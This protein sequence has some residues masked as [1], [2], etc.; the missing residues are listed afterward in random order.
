MRSC[1]TANASWPFCDDDDDASRGGGGA[2]R[3]SGS[4]R[5]SRRTATTTRSRTTRAARA[6]RAP[7]R[8]RARRADRRRARALRQAA[9]PDGRPA[10]PALLQRHQLRLRGAPPRQQGAARAAQRRERARLRR[11]AR[12]LARRPDVVLGSMDMGDHKVRLTTTANNTTI[13]TDNTKNMLTPL[14]SSSTT[15]SMWTW[16]TTRRAR[17]LATMCARADEAQARG[18]FLPP[19]PS[20]TQKVR[21]DLAALP[22][23]TIP[24]PARHRATREGERGWGAA[25]AAAA[26][27]G[28]SC[29]AAPPAPKFFAA[30]RGSCA[31]TG[32]GRGARGWTPASAAHELGR[33]FAGHRRGA[34]ASATPRGEVVCEEDDAE[35]LGDEA[36]AADLSQVRVP[37]GRRQGARRWRRRRRRAPAVQDGRVRRAHEHDVSIYRAPRLSRARASR[38]VGD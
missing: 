5:S 22:G 28:D 18:S 24:H 20:P 10:V 27:G 8:A 17:A 12:G 4:P 32:I 25:A 29:D 38:S 19:S 6:T 1:R 34:R 7:R 15:S 31:H 16:P 11:R 33:V 36:Q 37:G 14:S 21:D 13:N 3:R 2:R 9:E 30:F 23:V 35:A 26:S